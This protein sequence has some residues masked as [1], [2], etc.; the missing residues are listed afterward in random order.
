MAKKKSVGGLIFVMFLRSFIVVVL[1]LIVGMGSYALTMKYYEVT[2]SDA[3]SDNKL[4][5]VGDITADSVSRN[6]I[7]SVDP[8]SSRIDAMVI[9][10]LNTETNNLDF[11][12]IP[13]TLQFSINNEMYKRICAAGADA[14]QIIQFANLNE[15]FDKKT[16]YEYG[17]L[18]LEDYFG[19]DIGY[20]TKMDTTVFNN[21]FAKAGDNDF[22][23]VN[24]SLLQEASASTDEDSMKD[25]I[26]TKYDTL[27]SDVNLKTKQK[28][29]EYYS[30]V[31]PLFIYYYVIDGKFENGLFVADEE[32]VKKTYQTIL[33]EPA[34]TAAQSDSASIHSEGLNIKVLNGS[35]ADGIATATKQLLV[36]DGL[37]VIK[38][39]DNPEIIE[40]TQIYVSKD[41]M[42]KDLLSYFK[43]A[44]IQVKELEEGIDILVVVGSA[45]ADISSRQ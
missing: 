34:H 25:F 43:G 15:Y 10:I 30:K 44:E 16:S 23:I 40:K 13:N 7:Y 32:A 36:N 20:Y 22:Y 29:A 39:A 26:K 1:M 37:N 3:S 24:D 33:M 38:I 14:P 2:D 18:L 41:G 35:G 17:I 31:N 4:D 6:L 21:Y 8:E 42:G 5:I 27:E 45:D 11:I 19:I 9:E 28:Y 12:T